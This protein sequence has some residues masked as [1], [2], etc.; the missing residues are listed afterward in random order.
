MLNRF[1]ETGKIVGTHGI[2]GEVRV[3]PWSDSGEFLT[4]FKSFYLDGEGKELLKASAVRPHGNVVIISF[5][6]IAS[7]EQAEKLRGKIIYINRNDVDL[8]DGRYFVSDLIGCTVTDA[9]T[10]AALGRLS[11]VSQTGANDVWHIMRDG[12][13]YL[14]PA[15]E[16]VVISVDVDNSKVI[17]RP[18]KGIF[19]DED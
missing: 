6:G 12:R 18:I 2:K 16:E 9:D 14:V 13:E 15:V 1:I 17:I 19:D 11:E 10:G 5:K 3:Q 4:N 7:I 8:P